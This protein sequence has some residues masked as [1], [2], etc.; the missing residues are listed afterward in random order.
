MKRMLSAVTA[1]AA[2][3]LLAVAA[4]AAAG[5]ATSS[6]RTMSSSGSTGYK[7]AA[8]APVVNASAAPVI[9][10]RRTSHGKTLVD[11][12][13][14]TLYLFEADRPNMS[15]CTTSCLAVW[16]ALTSSKATPRARGG[17]VAGKIGTIRSHAGRQV[18]YAGH[19][20]Y[21]YVGDHKPGDT[22][23]QGLDQ[24]GAKWYVL[25]PSGRKI[26]DD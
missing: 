1:I 13:G 18:T 7:A 21:R 26:D 19:P 6:A 11:G 3:G 23:G 8:P 4:I 9:G 24:F 2:L 14:R 20:L 17:A 10:V 12:H 22:K 5:G 15:N 25:A 16:P